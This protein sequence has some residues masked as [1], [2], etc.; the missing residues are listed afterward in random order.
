MTDSVLKSA[1][2]LVDDDLVSAA[3]FAPTNKQSASPY[4]YFAVAAVFA[5]VLIGAVIAM[6][7]IHKPVAETTTA[8]SVQFGGNLSAGEISDG[9]IVY[10]NSPYS[11]KEIRDFIEKNKEIIA[12]NTAI[13]YQIFDKP[14]KIATKGYSPVYLGETNKIILD[15]LTLP[16]M[17]GDEIVGSVSLFK[18]NGELKFTTAAHGDTWGRLTN[19]LKENPDSEL[20]FFCIGL[21]KEFALTQDNK[22]YQ[23]TSPVTLLLDENVDY[24]AKFKTEYNVFSWEILNDENNYVTVDLSDINLN[25]EAVASQTELSTLFSQNITNSSLNT[26]KTNVDVQAILSK[27]ILSVEFN[28][29]F[30]MLRGYQEIKANEEQK[31]KII[32]YI[33]D[34]ECVE[35]E[36]YRQ[37]FGGTGYNINL[38][39]EDGTSVVIWLM[40][41]KFL[42]IET[43]QGLSAVYT[44]KSDNITELCRYIGKLSL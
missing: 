9:E 12:G 4:K 26:Q 34:V 16:I 15:N 21:Y 17:I 40:Q 37:G 38:Y 28:S 2:D 5:L 43:A 31:D 8:A 30:R 36:D 22:V 1:I 19:A 32:A 11:D 6:K 42:C 13:E 35:A 3:Y 18:S 7:D 20:A 25:S 41:E 29:N 23:I 10:E 27:E 44:D 24:Y 33:S 14:I 39:Y